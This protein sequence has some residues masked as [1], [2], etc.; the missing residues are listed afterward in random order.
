MLRQFDDWHES[1]TI[2]PFIRDGLFF[3][4]WTSCTLEFAERVLYSGIHLLYTLFFYVSTIWRIE[5]IIPTPK[6]SKSLKGPRREAVFA[7][8]R[9]VPLKDVKTIQRAFSGNKPGRAQQGYMGHVTV[10]DVLCSIMADCVSRAIER[11]P[12]ATDLWSNVKRASA[13]IL[14]MPIAF[15]M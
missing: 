15:F 11:K 1:A 13:T 14:P 4:Y 10:N 3:L 2:R 12:R 8:S 6:G 7:L 9:P 5:L